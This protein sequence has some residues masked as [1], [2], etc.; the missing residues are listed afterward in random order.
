MNG[1]T[2][3]DLIH[4]LVEIA[5]QMEFVERQKRILADEE[6]APTFRKANA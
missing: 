4:R 6:S 5:G 1:E 2:Y 3:D